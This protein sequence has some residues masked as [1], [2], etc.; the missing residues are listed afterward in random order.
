MKGEWI[1]MK[2][3]DEEEINVMSVSAFGIIMTLSD[4]RSSVIAFEFYF[5]YLPSLKINS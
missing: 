4:L 3:V 1:V 5:H 2:R